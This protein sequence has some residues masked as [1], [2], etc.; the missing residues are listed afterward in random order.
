MSNPLSAV[1]MGSEAKSTGTVNAAGQTQAIGA[2]KY[3]E[4]APGPV[5]D[6]SYLPTQGVKPGSTTGY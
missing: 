3:G 6:E 2:K 1:Q 4:D 5:G